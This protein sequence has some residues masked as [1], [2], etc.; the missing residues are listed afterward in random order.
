MREVS[1]AMNASVFSKDQ[2]KIGWVNRFSNSIVF[3][4]SHKDLVLRKPL[5]V[6]LLS[7]NVE[8]VVEGTPIY[9]KL[10]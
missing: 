8:R 7:A 1:E 9:A 10:I 6:S 2:M 4:P 5:I 3:P